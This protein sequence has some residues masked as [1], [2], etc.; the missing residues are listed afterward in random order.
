MKKI[1]LKVIPSHKVYV[2]PF[3]GSGALY[4]YKEP[5]QKEV[6]SDLD[7]QLIRDYKLIKK[8]SNPSRLL[9]NL[10]TITKLEK[11]ISKRHNTPEA[12]LTEAIIRRCNGFGGNYITNNTVYKPSNPF[13]KLKNID[14][15]QERMRNTSILL[16]N[17]KDVLK[18]YDS[19]DTFF[20]LDPPYEDSDKLYENDKI[21][22]SEMATILSKLKG[23][24]LLSLND[25]SNIRNIFKQFKQKRF[26]IKTLGNVGIGSNKTRKEILIYNY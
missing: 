24:F 6:I 15:Y 4:F 12:L 21:D 14:K 11:F 5:S 19:V 26:M 10:D 22:Y 7:S 13:N 23:K 20:Y 16:A 18:K 9:T 17:Y 25:S 3:V 8:I 1:L 2:E